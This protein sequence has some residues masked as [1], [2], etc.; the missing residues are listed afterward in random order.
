MSLIAAEPVEVTD[1]A[2]LIR[3]SRT[4]RPGMSVG[5]LYDATRGIWK[6]SERREKARL[7]LAVHKGV[8]QEVYDITEW[9]PAGTTWYASR[10]FTAEECQRRW[11]FIGSVASSKDRVRYVG[12]SVAHYFQKGDVNPVK[13]CNI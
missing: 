12:K 13:Y 7:A 5:D 4:Y 10:R 11:E 9:H 2:L 1:P 3:I 6:I 8:V